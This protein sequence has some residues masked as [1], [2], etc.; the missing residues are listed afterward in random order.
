LRAFFD[1]APG[2]ARSTIEGSRSP[3]GGWSVVQGMAQP[4]PAVVVEQPADGSWTLAAWSL[5]DESRSGPGLA[6]A[7]RMQRWTGAEDW[8]VILPTGVGQVK[9]QRR[10]GRIDMSASSGRGWSLKLE[11]GPDVSEATTELS[12]ALASA[13]EKYRTADTSLTYRVK[14][15]VVLLIALLLNAII[16]RV[17]RR[18]R[19]AWTLVLGFILAAGWLL[20]SYYFV[21]LRAQL[22]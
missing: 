8:E 22:V 12:A 14:V 20:V 13:S 2:A 1:G 16:L 10:Q 21:F 18:Y 7:P 15:T 11:P 19:P 6:G 9:L 17:V 4:A 5:A 3:F